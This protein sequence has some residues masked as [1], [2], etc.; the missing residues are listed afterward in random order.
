MIALNAAQLAVLDWI[1]NGCPDVVYLAENYSQRISARALQS[2][3]LIQVSGHGDR[4]RAWLTEHGKI[5][6]AAAVKDQEMREYQER[7]KQRESGHHE[8][9]AGLQITLHAEP[10]ARGGATVK[11]IRRISKPKP[12]IPLKLP[13]N[14]VSK[15][16]TYMN[17]KVVV[18]RVQVA[19]R[20]VRAT[21]EEHPT[22]KM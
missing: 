10:D 4:R 20:W 6:P 13:F 11:A 8:P 12:P 2:C 15:Q 9:D 19:E 3:G 7:S 1:K 16:E 5:W 17:D 18:T 22:Q 21:D 14:Q